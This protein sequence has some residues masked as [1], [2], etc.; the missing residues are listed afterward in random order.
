MFNQ[1]FVNRTSPGP[2][3]HSPV[4]WAPFACCP[5]LPKYHRNHWNT[6]CSDHI[7]QYFYEHMV[8]ERSTNLQLPTAQ[9]W[10]GPSN[11]LIP[12]WTCELLLA[13]IGQIRRPCKFNRLRPKL[14]IRCY[15]EGTLNAYDVHAHVSNSITVSARSMETTHH[16]ELLECKLRKDASRARRSP[17]TASGSIGQNAKSIREISRGT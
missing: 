17:R 5:P 6:L 13:R 7:P 11:P 1:Q 2:S 12:S 3:L 8:L 9:E 15:V 4:G 14:A 10:L 16:E